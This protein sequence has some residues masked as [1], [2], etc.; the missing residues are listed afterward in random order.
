VK[1][2]LSGA[3]GFSP[4]MPAHYLEFGV[5]LNTVKIFFE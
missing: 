2:P 3:G 4:G 1:I 5:L